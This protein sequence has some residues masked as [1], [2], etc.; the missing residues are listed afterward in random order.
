MASMIFDSFYLDM[1][2]GNVGAGATYKAMLVT[3]SY[4]PDK[5]AHSKRSHVTN[6]V[7]AGSGY[8]AGGLACTLTVAS[9]TANHRLTFTVP[10]INWPSASFPPSRGVVIYRSRGGASSADELVLYGDFTADRSTTGATFTVTET[11]L[12]MIQN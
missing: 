4:V 2:N 11:S 8:T 7:P 1:W 3:S 10:D 6:E 5:G 9:D 12:A